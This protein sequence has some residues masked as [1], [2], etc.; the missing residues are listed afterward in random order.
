MYQ[1]VKLD[2]SAHAGGSD[3]GVE[4]GSAPSPPGGRGGLN[5]I[6]LL[7]EKKHKLC[8]D[9]SQTISAL[10]AAIEAATEVP[11]EKQRLI[12]GGKQLTEAEKTLTS[13]KI[14]DGASIHLFPKVDLPSPA[15]DL[16]NVANPLHGSGQTPVPVTDTPSHRPAVTSATTDRPVNY[17]VDPR[18]VRVMQRQ[19]PSPRL[20]CRHRTRTLTPTIPNH[21]LCAACR[22]RCKTH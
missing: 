18:L 13:Y 20:L 12:Y 11:V 5:V 17:R 2:D 16:A 14:V 3:A 21:F 6:V 8:A 19:E 4:L 15:V 10:K 9:S 7:K 22:P 1:P